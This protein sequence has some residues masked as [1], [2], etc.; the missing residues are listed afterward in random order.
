MAQTAVHKHLLAHSPQL[1]WTHFE[2]EGPDAAA[3][4]Q[5]VRAALDE[6]GTPPKPASAAKGVDLDTA[7]IDE[8]M[9]AQGRADGGIYKFSFARE[10][11]PSMHGRLLPPPMGVTTA[12]NFQPTGD[13]MAAVNGDFVMAADEVQAVIRALREGGVQ[14]VELHHHTLEEE[15]RLTYLH[16]WGE[17]DAVGLAGALGKAVAATKVVPVG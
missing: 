10:E 3:L 12:V 13:G 7:A 6:T 5:A 16:F 8:A 15:P 11:E 17:A 2:A 4:A 1:W 9:G 14:I